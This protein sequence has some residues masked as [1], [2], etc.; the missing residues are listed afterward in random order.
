M[1]IAGFIYVLKQ[2]FS[3]SQI[4]TLVFL[5]GLF[6]HDR[7][8]TGRAQKLWRGSGGW[9]RTA[10][11]WTVK[12]WSSKAFSQVSH[13]LPSALD[14]QNDFAFEVLIN[15]HCEQEGGSPAPQSLTSETFF[16]QFPNFCCL[17]KFIISICIIW[18]IKS[19]QNFWLIKCWV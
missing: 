18:R 14:L 19:G 4:S 11:N 12:I 17:A 7:P 16:H 10:V 3:V 13:R 2:F 6:R 5:K 15:D 9:L 8:V 1:D